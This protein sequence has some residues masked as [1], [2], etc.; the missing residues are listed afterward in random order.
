MPRI[1]RF[2]P[3]SFGVLLG[4]LITL[5]IGAPPHSWADTYAG[6]DQ[7]YPSGR[8]PSTNACER[9]YRVLYTSNRDGAKD[10]FCL[11]FP[12]NFDRRKTY[13]V[14]FKFKPWYG[15]G[16]T[17]SHPNFAYNLC[18]SNQVIYIG[19]NE[20]GIGDASFGDNT[21][22]PPA[23]ASAIPADMLELLSQL[24]YLFNI[25][26]VASFGASMGGY[27]ALRFMVYLPS[28]YVGV[29]TPSC[30]ALWFREYVQDGSD[31]IL[32]AVR[33]GHFNDKF[34][35]IMH[36]TA[37]D[38][39]PIEVSRRLTAA[40]PQTNWWQ[41]VEAQGRVHE[42]FFC[43]LHTNLAFPDE[44]EWGKS[45][46]VPNIWQQ[47]KGWEA[48]HPPYVNRRLPPLPGWT[49]PT[50]WYLPKAVVLPGECVADAGV[51]QTVMD[52]ATNGWAWVT[53]NGSFSTGPTEPPGTITNYLWT[54]QGQPLANGAVATAKVPVGTNLVTLTVQDDLGGSDSDTVTIK[55]IPISF[56]KIQRSIPPLTDIL[57]AST[58]LTH[59]DI[60]ED[61]FSP[62]TNALYVALGEQGGSDSNPGTLL[63]PFEHLETAI[64]YANAHAETPFTIYLRGGVH[65]YK[66]LLLD[67]QIR[68]GNLYITAYPNEV[69]T[70]RPPSWPGYPTDW[71]TEYA[72]FVVGPYSNI[73][74]DNLL[75]EGWE[76]IFHLGAPW[77][78]NQDAPLRNVT[79]KNIVA[80]DFRHRDGDTN[81]F[82]SFLDTEPLDND[83]YGEGKVIFDEPQMAHYQIE[84]LIVSN[85]WVLDVDLGINIGDEND[86]NVKGLRISR[87][88]LHN[89]PRDF[90]D[91]NGTDGVGIVNSYK[92]LIDNCTLENIEN[93]GIDT[94][95][96]DVSVVNCLVKA[97]VR[98]A[99]KLW[100][101][102]E[103]I[104]SIIY[105]STWIDDGALVVQAGGPF[106]IVHS[107]IIS[108]T[109]GYTA[110]LNCT[111]RDTQVSG[112][113]NAPGVIQYQ[114]V[115][116]IFSDLANPFYLET[117]HFFSRACLYDMPEAYALFT[118]GLPDV[119]NVDELNLLDGSF[120]NL[121]SPPGLANPGGDDFTP[122]EGSPCIDAGITTGVLLPVFDFYGRPRVSGL[123]P[124]IGPVEFNASISPR[125]ASNQE[126]NNITISWPLSANGFVLEQTPALH[127]S[128]GSWTMIPA[129]QYQSN[130]AVYYLSITLPKEVQFFRLRQQ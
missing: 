19:C 91:S 107:A 74:F 43:I 45:D 28:D 80:R 106:R 50:N 51:D 53:L 95:C 101:N 57:A 96:Y 22:L 61:D 105:G 86:A 71:F 112:C 10:F 122:S 23:L 98:N 24:C 82:R 119:A 41:L 117:T 90:T 72:F 113:T 125:L 75:F 63:Q 33:N 111:N 89:L 3:H 120:G 73:T 60:P 62:P 116:S 128:I 7:V 115:N 109:N 34:V 4:T 56:P 85:V 127:G 102:G 21:N 37:D 78:S 84:N 77:A 59:G 26:Y 88:D 83:V 18:D 93:D 129:S 66:D 65:D 42:E 38:T 99:V 100:R 58:F 16:T 92:I 67:S 36:G 9:P 44:E 104:N 1:K 55:V 76:V 48:A 52:A 35:M 46:V 15:S 39:V 81:S 13:P 126:G 54:L 29:T 14:W 31:L 40:A 69:A 12:Y 2:L 94:K 124:D 5:A 114:L 68:R 30:P 47:I 27:S 25:N 70:I 64:D 123:A 108:K 87:F 32:D 130:T 103:L 11:S 110:T 79:L 97:S 121:S 49:R 8:Y 118:G 6:Y 17:I 20:R